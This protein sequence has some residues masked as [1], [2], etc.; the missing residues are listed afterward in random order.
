MSLPVTAAEG[1]RKDL[2]P[3]A[4]DA[5]GDAFMEREN[6][7]LYTEHPG[8]GYPGRQEPAAGRM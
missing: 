6:A 8:P 2:A 5:F 7:E 4:A 1:Y 3:V